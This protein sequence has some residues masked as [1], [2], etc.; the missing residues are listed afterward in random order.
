MQQYVTIHLFACDSNTCEFIDGCDYAAMRP[1][2]EI[3]ALRNSSSL[4][5]DECDGDWRLV[6]GIQSNRR[7]V[8]FS[9]LHLFTSFLDPSSLHVRKGDSM[10]MRASTWKPG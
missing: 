7:F 1:T 3:A 4:C 5:L 8:T 6:D 10:V 9:H 2:C